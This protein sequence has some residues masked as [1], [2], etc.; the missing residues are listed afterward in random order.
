MQGIAVSTAQSVRPRAN[1][2]L[3]LDDDPFVPRWIR[4]VAEHEG[5]DV[6]VSG[7]LQTVRS[8]CRSFRPTLILIDLTLGGYQGLDALRLLSAER[9][10]MPIIL[11]G[12]AEAGVLHSASRFGMTLDLS[13]A[14]I[15]AK[16]IELGQLR[17]ALAAHVHG[18]MD[19]ESSVI[20]RMLRDSVNRDGA[21]V[22]ANGAGTV[23]SNAG[24]TISNG[25]LGAAGATGAAGVSDVPRAEDEARLRA[26][27]DAEE[28]RVHYQPQIALATGAVVGVEALVR[29]QHP[30]RGLISA[31]SFLPLAERLAL[32]RPLTM[33]V[34]ESAL[35]EARGWARSG[36]P[37]SVA[38][39]LAG[40]L[41]N[42]PTLA[43]E[44]ERQCEARGVAP[45]M[46]T[47]EISESATIGHAQ[48]VVDALTRLRV[49]GCRLSLDNFG[50]GFSSL[51]ELRTLPFSQLKIDKTFVGDAT[52]RPAARAIVDAVIEFGHKIGLQI[53]A[54]GVETREALV[55]LKEA[56]CDF[57]QGF[58]ISRPVDAVALAKQLAA[59]PL[60]QRAQTSS[61]SRGRGH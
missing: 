43:D 40:S 51:V 23:T 30:T 26:A 24:V 1:R 9:C 57:A 21:N 46:L 8:L 15:I 18:I 6:T 28:L 22:A 58:L 32:M 60:P 2:L 20:G 35:D 50:T 3:V 12:A 54:E 59:G 44:I 11:T 48:D 10:T 53:V 33:F 37:V 47:L 61:A 52:S 27:V 39:N 56:G 16:P 31:N 42:D 29:W 49:K 5:Y 17:R 34:L 45:E 41:L 7:D 38:V 4:Q 55:I 13:M 36:Q 19:D 14:G 25:S